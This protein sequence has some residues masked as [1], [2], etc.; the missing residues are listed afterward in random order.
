[1][2]DM[3]EE[4]PAEADAVLITRFGGP[5]VLELRRVPVLPPAAGE[6]AVRVVAAGVNPVETKIR[7]GIRGD[8]TLPA[9]F[10]ADAAGV[11]AAVGDGAPFS[12]GDE[13]IGWGQ[14]GTYA[15]F[16]TGP[17]ARWTPKPAGV[18]FAEGAALGIPAS[19]AYQC[20]R[21]AG[22]AAG[23]TL[24]VHA[25]AGAVGQAAVQFGVLWGARVIATAS[26]RNHEKLRALGAE[27]VAYGPGLLERVRELAPDSVDVVLE[28]AGTDEALEVSL[29]VARDR[30]RI[31]EIVVPGWAAEHGVTVFSGGL[32]GS[33]TA[34]ATALRDEA[35]AYT[36][37][38]IADR[39][40][41]VDIVDALPLAE[42]ARAHERVEGGHVSGKIVLNPAGP[43]IV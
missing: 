34:E 27:P 25:G 14:P 13:V 23:E 38:L 17:A 39:R 4:L 11:V 9:R 15:Q 43:H 8:V 37:G 18:G 42:A 22:L 28:G 12:V 2:R 31:V 30:K 41:V 3:S 16:V 10:G 35:V 1:M 24:L 33:M 19:T 5:D 32:P 21:S 36:A 7:R 29:A 40:F 20:L 26:P 6:I